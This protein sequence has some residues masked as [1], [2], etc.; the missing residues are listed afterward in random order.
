[1]V[2]KAETVQAS[3]KA[4]KS[5]EIK[6]EA[7]SGPALLVETVVEVAAMAALGVLRR[8]LGPILVPIPAGLVRV[9]GA[10]WTLALAVPWASTRAAL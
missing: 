4:M 2:I 8:L 10:R 7:A 5:T 9:Q 6:E 3:P 1:M